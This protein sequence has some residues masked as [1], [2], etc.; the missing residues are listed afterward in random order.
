MKEV[1]T[2]QT[3]PLVVYDAEAL[4]HRSIGLSCDTG[5]GSMPCLMQNSMNELTSAWYV[6]LVEAATWRCF[7]R[8]S[9]SVRRVLS[10]QGWVLDGDLPLETDV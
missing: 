6:R 8:V 9:C 5:S 4:Q 7:S 3:N 2:C 1:D 10:E